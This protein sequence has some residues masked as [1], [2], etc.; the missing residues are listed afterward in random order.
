MIRGIAP[1]RLSFAGGGSDLASYYESNGGG[2]VVSACINRYAR[3]TLMP[4]SATVSTV[5]SVDLRQ[6]LNI[7][8]D[9]GDD[10]LGLVRT[11][12]RRFDAPSKF[13]LTLKSDAPPGSGLGS[14]SS[15]TVCL[16]AMFNRWLGKPMDMGELA[17]LAYEVERVEFGVPGG[18]QDQVAA[19]YGGFNYIAFTK[20]G[21]QVTP[22]RLD[23]DIVRELEARLVLAYTGAARTSTGLIGVQEER[24][25]SGS[26]VAALHQARLIAG[27]MKKL[28]LQGDLDAVGPLLHQAWVAKKEFAPGITT[29]DIDAMYEAG[30]RAGATGGKLLGAGGGGYLM[31]F[32]D[33]DDR[34]VVEKA[35]GELGATV[36]DA[37]FAMEGVETWWTQA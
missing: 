32:T 8:D 35:L 26:N 37:S 6:V 16:L 36:V 2:A 22:L 34:Y 5:Q 19:A 31:M 9:A 10:K 28:L 21:F 24:T 1:L 17:R 12:L 3:G 15:L 11:A 4:T 30:M 29:P 33:G 20:D 25:R 23:R 13:R 14:S 18:W 7:P 27:A